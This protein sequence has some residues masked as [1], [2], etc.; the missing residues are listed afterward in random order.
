MLPTYGWIE[1]AFIAVLY[2]YYFQRVRYAGLRDWN[3][4][5]RHFSCNA[6]FLSLAFTVE[7]TH[8]FRCFLFA[9]IS[10]NG[11]F[12]VSET[13]EGQKSAKNCYFFARIDTKKIINF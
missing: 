1:K 4:K 11:E 5:F 10:P 6:L 7:L 12:N 3:E 9:K 2:V 13:R 8:Q